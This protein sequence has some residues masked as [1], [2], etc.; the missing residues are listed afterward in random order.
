LQD[1]VRARRLFAAAAAV[2]LVGGV[3]GVIVVRSR[4]STTPVSVDDAVRPSDDTTT[5][6]STAAAD[7]PPVAG[8]SGAPGADGGS[9]DGSPST[10]P[11]GGA[12]GV[13]PSPGVYVYATSGSE[14]VD[15]LGGA[16]HTYPDR[17][18]ITYALTDCGVSARWDALEERWDEQHS[19][20]TLDGEWLQTQAQHHEFSGRP[21]QRDYTCD[22]L[23]R[24]VETDVGAMWSAECSDADSHIAITSQLVGVET[25]T[26]DSTD[27]ESLHLHADGTVTGSV[28]GTS[29]YD[30]WVDRSSGLLLRRV[31]TIDTDADSPSGTTHYHEDYRID[32]SSLTPSA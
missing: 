24:P 28:R 22:G 8:D 13:R 4:D 16:Q 25:V 6:T 14:R 9:A 30:V 19:C 15:A 1:S 12:V 2:V 32:L 31:V 7:A 26:V 3:V 17:T 10:V 29:S 20:V 18:T 5:T 21:D 23:L 11:D 27:V